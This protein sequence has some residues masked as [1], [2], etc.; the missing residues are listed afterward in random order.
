MTSHPEDS[1]RF[2]KRLSTRGAAL[3]TVAAA[4]A[5]VVFVVAMLLSRTTRLRAAA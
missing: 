5:V 2:M 1:M 4:L 3:I